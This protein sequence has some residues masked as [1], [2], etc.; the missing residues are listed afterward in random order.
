VGHALAL[1]LSKEAIGQY[2]AFAATLIRITGSFF[3]YVPLVTVLGRWPSILRATRRA[4]PMLILTTGAFVGPFLGVAMFMVA[5]RHAHAGVVAT[6][7]A[8]M[9]VLILPLVI[10]VYKE[11]VSLRAAAGALVSVVGVALLML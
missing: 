9:P 8:T 2:D 4:R 5:V 10:C 3:G 6:L 7:L 11:K 1:V